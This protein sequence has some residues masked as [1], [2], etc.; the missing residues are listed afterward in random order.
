MDEIQELLA[1]VAAGREQWRWVGWV[2][3]VTVRVGGWVGGGG[4]S[5]PSI[6]APV[7]ARRYSSTK[8]QCAED[9]PA[10]PPA[11]TRS[12]EPATATG[13]CLEARKAAVASTAASRERG[14]DSLVDRW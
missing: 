4:G 10:R 3:G 6:S 5:M 14:L 7:Q 12:R 11:H 2:R 8:T 9:A 1:C 13:F